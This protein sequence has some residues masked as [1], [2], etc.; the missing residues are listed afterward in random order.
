MLGIT[1]E[2]NSR[3]SLAEQIVHGVRARIDDRV[4]RPGMRL[5]PIRGMA[6]GLGVSRFTV[7]EAYDRLV[8]SGL[9]ASRRGS[10]FYVSAAAS[11][12]RR[13]G[14]APVEAEP[15]ERVIERALDNADVMR[16]ALSDDASRLKVGTGWL[17]AGWLDEPG[18]RRRLRALAG[19]DGLR[20]SRYG[21][22]QGYLPLRQQLGVR[23]DSLGIAAPPSQILLT[24]GATQALD[25]VART[26]LRPGDAALVDDPGY[27]NLFA[28][29]RLLGVRLI[30]VPRQVDGPDVAALEAL[31]TEHRPKLFITQ[32][33]LHNPTAGNLSPAVAHRVLQLA[34]RHD[35]LVVEDDPYADYSPGHTARLAALDGLDRV[36]YVGS[37]SKTLSANLRVGFLA[38][39]PD[40]LRTFTDVKLFTA[41]SSSEFAERLIHGLLVDGHYRKFIDRLKGRLAGAM[42]AALRQL[43][44]AGFATYT[45]PSGGMFVWAA[46]AG[47][48]LAAASA[49][50]RRAALQGIVLPPGHLFRPQLQATPFL[51]FNVA[52]MDDPRF[53][54]LLAG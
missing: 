1:I 31:L 15:L 5:P 26:L 48:E 52:Y 11:P 18:L 36:I 4:L 6:A 17:P 10:G 20:L 46:P 28:A 14:A 41:V 8:A 47:G 30:G 34:A 32:S 53:V 33:V 38:A 51:R 50:T 40:L 19:Q 7:V 54:R 42:A 24:S 49:L 29:L 39:R 44:E 37:F 27:W 3:L 22:P 43:D 45:E 35:C 9:V 12:A 23:L 25:L 16:D 21:E 13:A 2:P